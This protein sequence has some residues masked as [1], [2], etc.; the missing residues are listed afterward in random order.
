MSSIILIAV[1]VIAI[2][3]VALFLVA[4][5][6]FKVIQQLVDRLGL[7]IKEMLTGIRVIRAYGNDQ[8]QQDKFN[9][10]NQEST[11][12]NVF[13]SRVM[14]L[15]QPVMTVVMGLASVAVIWTGAYIIAAGHLQ[16]GNILALTQ[17]V[18]QA[19]M[20]FLMLSIIFIMIPRA[21]V[22]ARRINDVLKVT[23]KI[24]DPEQPLE[25]KQPIKGVIEFKH[26]N[27]NYVGSEQA[28][29]SD[30]S[31]VAHPGKTTA[32]IGGTGSGKSTLVSLIP[33]FY[34]V[35][36]GAITIDGIDIRNFSQQRLHELIGYIPQKSL[37]FSGTIQSNILYG[38]PGADQ[39][40]VKKAA[41]IAQAEE[42]IDGL[43][44]G[45][46][47]PIAQ[48]GS[49]VSGGQK[50]R[51]TIA[52]ALVK[53]PPIF[54]FDDSFSALD[55]K[56]DAALRQALDREL[57]DSTIIIIAQRISTI[58]KADNI[59][60]LDNGRIVG[61]GRHEDLLAT[62]PVYRE[63]AESQLSADELNLS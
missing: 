62:S 42:F 25:P 63:I 9:R 1:S 57:K 17:Y 33:R 20:A 24:K 41:T 55:F 37:L 5:P 49:N 6:K 38:Q 3:V 12:L 27:F 18:A 35:T 39:E 2:M 19:I 10:I 44:E 61:Q 36:D 53:R 60:V 31:F 46:D 30:I 43:A 21:A 32:I 8:G 15:M 51:L 58:M 23:P 54:L 52:R 26:V 11:D 48:G 50:Q 14:S 56:T 4:I 29:L 34:D 7:Q 59:I 16:I 13:I 22:S 40:Q 45:F 28:V 47:S